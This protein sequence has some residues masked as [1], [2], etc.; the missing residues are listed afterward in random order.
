MRKYIA[1]YLVGLIGLLVTFEGIAQETPIS[2]DEVPMSVQGYFYS[3]YS[4][5]KEVKW[6][7]INNIGEELIRITFSMKDADK[8]V[9]MTMNGDIQEEVS[10]SKKANIDYIM[11]EKSLKKHPDGKVLALRKVTKFNLQGFTAPQSYYE[12]SLKN[13]KEIVY[14][15]FD[16][17]KQLLTND[18]V[19]DL[20]VN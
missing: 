12:V 19:F 14:V 17:D 2:E 1:C 9:V 13:G 15:Y 16:N 8:N 10:V 3:H 5:A 20:A 4:N 18:N 6:S 11:S 7:N